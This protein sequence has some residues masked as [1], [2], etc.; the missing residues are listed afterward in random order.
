[1]YT[2]VCIARRGR[3]F[4]YVKET[5]YFRNVVVN[6]EQD[7]DF[8]KKVNWK[9]GI[10]LFRLQCSLKVSLMIEDFAGL[11]EDVDRP[12]PIRKENVLIIGL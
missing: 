4:S 12:A 5:D 10:V 11:L 8:K 2:L 1:M 3:T 9:S 7:I 6:L